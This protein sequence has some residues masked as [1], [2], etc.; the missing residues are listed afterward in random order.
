MRLVE[1]KTKGRR[2]AITAVNVPRASN[3]TTIGGNKTTI[4]EQL[5][6]LL[7]AC[8]IDLFGHARAELKQP[9]SHLQTRVQ[10]CCHVRTSVLDLI[11]HAATLFRV[12]LCTG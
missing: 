6:I 9:D 11:V 7:K 4:M 5:D 8:S 12:L 1:V 10:V 3:G 2:S